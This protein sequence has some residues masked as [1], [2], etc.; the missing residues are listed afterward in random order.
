MRVLQ[1]AGMRLTKSRDGAFAKILA[2]M[3]DAA[4]EPMP[5]DI[6]PVLHRLLPRH[7]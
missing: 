1:Q 7:R 3:Y 4:G 2:L 6:F 5:E